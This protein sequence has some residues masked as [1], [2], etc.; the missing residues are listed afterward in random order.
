MRRSLGTRVSLIVMALRLSEREQENV[1]LDGGEAQRGGIAELQHVSGSSRSLLWAGITDA[2]QSPTIPGPY[3]VEE[4]KLKHRLTKMDETLKTS[5]DHEA[6]IDLAEKKLQDSINGEVEALSNDVHKMNIKY[7]DEIENVEPVVGVPGPPGYH[8]TNGLD[9]KVGPTGPTGLQGP[10]GPK[11]GAGV[12]G[13]PG[14][15]GKQGPEGPEGP[16]GFSGKPR[17]VPLVPALR[18][19]PPL[20]TCV[21]HAS[22]A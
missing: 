11:G 15:M 22:F 6:K 5:A 1:S 12:M 7:T 18:R 3:L 21:K 8:G 17:H 20:C 19:V 13:P 9:G 2:D 14:V 10:P 16:G 4:R